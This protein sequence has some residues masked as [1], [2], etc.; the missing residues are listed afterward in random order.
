M[1]TITRDGITFELREDDCV[2]LTEHAS[3]GEHNDYFS[4]YWFKKDLENRGEQIGEQNSRVLYPFYDGQSIDV[5]P[6]VIQ[7]LSTHHPELLI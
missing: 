2:H 6:G 7:L 3:D 4:L 5:Y 1:K